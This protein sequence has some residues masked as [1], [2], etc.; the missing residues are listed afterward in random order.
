M[1][2][3]IFIILFS[4]IMQSCAKPDKSINVAATDMNDV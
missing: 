4:L 1:E 2:K 3:V